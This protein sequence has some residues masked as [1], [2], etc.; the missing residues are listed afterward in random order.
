MTS[1][2][3]FSIMGGFAALLVLAMPVASQAPETSDDYKLHAGDS[4]TVSVW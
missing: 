4:I 1:V 2:S 3:R